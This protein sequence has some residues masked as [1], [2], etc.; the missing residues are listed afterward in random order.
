MIIIQNLYHKNS[1][2]NK[3]IS[4][5]SIMDSP[6]SLRLNKKIILINIIKH[7]N[8]I[9]ISRYTSIESPKA[10]VSMD[11]TNCKSKCSNVVFNLKQ[12]V[13]LNADGHAYH[14]THTI[15]SRSFPGVDPYAKVD[16]QPLQINL[17]ESKQS[18][19]NH[20]YDDIK[21]LN[22]DDMKLAE[23]IQPTT[24][25]RWV[26]IQYELEISQD[27]EGTCWIESPTWSLLMFLQPPQLPSYGMVVAPSGWNPTVYD[28][29]IWNLPNQVYLQAAPPVASYSQAPS[30]APAPVYAPAPAP[31]Y[32]PAPAPVYAP[33]PAPVY[34]QA[35][36]PI[37]APVY[38][39]V[40]E[41]PQAQVSSMQAYPNQNNET[42]EHLNQESSQM[43][44]GCFDIVELKEIET[45]DKFY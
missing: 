13:T 45:T 36:A 23:F 21:P 8:Y 30:Y 2:S 43:E 32:A 1:N 26:N 28:P 15:L 40:S 39:P 34:A 18:Y 41:Q 3:I 11:N 22:G 14:R 4:R 25:G 6:N 44:G 37:P 16:N 12:V 29:V 9:K 17:S 27:Y 42:Y 20:M 10:L 24:N 5:N 35:P 31:V 33:A 7:F 38:A 19:Q